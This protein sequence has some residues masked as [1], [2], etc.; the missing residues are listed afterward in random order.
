MKLEEKK[1]ENKANVSQH[2][3]NSNSRGGAISNGIHNN[4]ILWPVAYGTL[5][6]LYPNEPDVRKAFLLLDPCHE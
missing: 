5:D 4:N 6:E 1:M 3:R 2:K